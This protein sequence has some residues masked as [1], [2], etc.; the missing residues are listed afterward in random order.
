MTLKLFERSD[1]MKRRSAAAIIISAFLLV[2]SCGC[3]AQKSPAQSSVQPS[4]E[5][6][7]P[8]S[9]KETIKI[10]ECKIK[11]EE[12]SFGSKK[13]IPDV[14]VTY[15]NKT[16]V[17]GTDYSVTSG[18][19]ELV[20]GKNELKVSMMGDYEGVQKV[21][22]YVLPEAPE[23][24]VTNTKVFSF[25][26]SWNE[27]AG[28]EGYELEYYSAS[29]PENKKTVKA[30]KSETG[31][32]INDLDKNST[33]TIRVRAFVKAH[34]ENVYSSWSAPCSA[35]LK[36]L[37][38]V[39]GVTYVDGVLIVNKTYSLPESYGWGEDQE[40]LQA[41]YQMQQDAAADNKWIEIISGYRSY[42]TQSYT[43]QSF[44]DDRGQYEADRVSA[45]PG[46]SEHQTG[47]AFDINST[48]FAFTYTPEAQWLAENCTKY[49]FI[50]R[51][52]EGKEDITGYQYESWHIRYL[53]V[54][55]AKEISES[56][57][58]VEEYYGITS[59]YSD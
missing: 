49:G 4:Q 2:L 41:F 25:T 31:L 44:I 46:H 23:L 9:E 39:D 45:R 11:V 42:A 26:V 43:Y 24:T 6:T 37:E 32:E 53:G 48:A 15:N 22:F 35:E 30:D 19:K 54:E 13:T 14:T 16:L 5:V 59:E 7:E 27:T 21:P 50:I 3:S 28:A 12:L 33:Y 18:G 36:K 34:D 55:K 8:V 51:Y 38:T 52:P 58:T 1:N 29:S 17:E 20:P 47:L 40:A 57:L 10:T 56:G